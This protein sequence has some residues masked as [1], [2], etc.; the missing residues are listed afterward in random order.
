MTRDASRSR[1]RMARAG[2]ALLVATL[3]GCGA[4][5]GPVAAPE[6]EPEQSAAA[7]QDSAPEVSGTGATPEDVAA[8]RAVLAQLGSAIN[9]R[10]ADALRQLADPVDG[11][12]LWSQPG[13]C[14]TPAYLL[15]P[16]W[17]DD[18]FAREQE[19][20]RSAVFFEEV[21]STLAATLPV[22]GQ[23]LGPYDI[24]PEEALETAPPW[25]SLDTDGDA[26]R[27]RLLDFAQSLEGEEHIAEVL[28]ILERAPIVL[29]LDS[30]FH[31][32]IVR[33]VITKRGDRLHV[34]HVQL[35]WLYDA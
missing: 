18:P 26:I 23:D 21:G 6:P 34:A 15:R 4:A 27:S 19:L 5:Q 14:L 22:M 29:E 30:A 12:W 24:P 31:S 33:V 16:D 7:E 2:S 9:A 32:A 20:V 13:C 28:A 1:W 25:A 35:H 11:M 17:G 3:A 8:A 10:D